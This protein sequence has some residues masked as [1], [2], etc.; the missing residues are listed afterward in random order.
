MIKLEIDKMETK[1]VNYNFERSLER[2]DDIIDSADN[3]YE[4]KGSDIPSR[5]NLT[6]TNGFYVYVGAIF[7]DIRDSSS[8]SDTHRRPTLAKIY[9]SFISEVVAI[10]NG[11]ETCNEINIIG[12]CVSG[13]FATKTKTDFNELFL[14]AA[15]I[16]SLIN[17]INCKLS[18]KNIQNIKVGIG[19]DYGRALMIKAGYKGSEIN[20][21]VWMGDVV[22]NA[23]KLCD[24]ANR[25]SSEQILISS[26]I[27]NNLNGH[28]KSLCN[29]YSSECYEANVVDT[30]MN[31]WWD[32][33]C[34]G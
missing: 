19:I 30:S 20:E 23:S 8:L 15:R 28:N 34:G 6:F 17:T 26:T 25:R 29:Y 31:D 27:Y 13:I 3:N 1:H 5:N 10:M 14:T 11:D 22:N 18:K 16:N 12:D 7:V 2:I 32:E 33:N 21:I 24:N 4:E 9:R